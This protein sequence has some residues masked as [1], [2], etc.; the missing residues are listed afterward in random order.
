MGTT[1]VACMVIDDAVALCA[2]VGDSRGY[3]LR[4][5][6]LHQIT[7]DHSLVARMVEQNRLTAEEARHHPHSNILL[8]T[9]GTERNVDIDIFRVDLEPDD[10]LLLCSDGLWGEVEDQEIESVLIQQTDPRAAAR[11]LIRAAHLGGGKDNISVVM[12]TVPSSVGQPTTAE[13]G[14]AVPTPTI[15]SLSTSG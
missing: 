3:L 12:A 14:A 6:S 8:R 9:V 13:F 15:R 1:L 4:N 11:E 5:G 2:N 7:R 10:R